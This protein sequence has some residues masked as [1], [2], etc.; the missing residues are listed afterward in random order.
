MSVIAA[1]LSGGFRRDQFYRE[2][3]P[4]VDAAS[5]SGERMTQDDAVRTIAVYA[6]GSLLADTVSTLP[7][8]A[9]VKRGADRL[10]DDLPEWLETP[11]PT[12]PS[13]TRI[14]HMS[15]LM[16]SMVLDNNSFTL[17][18]PDVFDPSE[19]RVCNPTRVEARSSRSGP[20]YRM[21]M[22][23]GGEEEVGPDQM[24]HISRARLGGTGRGISP[25]GVMSQSLATKRAAERLAAK[26]FGNGMFLSG[27][28]LLPGPAAP[29]VIDKL[30]ADI[31]EQYAGAENA[32]KPG[33]FANGA[34]WDVPAINLEQFQLLE[35]NQNVVKEVARAYRIAPYLLGITEP[36]AMA[37]ASVEAQ[38]I[39]FEKF[40]IRPY[41]E[42]I[43]LAYRRLMPGAYIKFDT[44]GLL[45]GDFKTRMEGYAL[46]TGAR[47]QTPAEVRALEDLPPLGSDAVFLE[48]PNNN[49]PDPRYQNL[50]RLVQAGYDPAESLAALG[51]PSIKHTGLPPVTVQPEIQ[52]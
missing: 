19:L 9:Y 48:T 51:L 5:W 3:I 23:G 6:A 30:R 18:L 42:R 1:I 8:H 50:A 36:G 4:T 24:V 16:W 49:A 31:T 43:E 15:Q 47:I 7:V 52:P 13:L 10:P 20:R 37:N 12:D 44:K 22:D 28:V 38:G 26:V 35:T 14:D 21:R 40:T 33:V 17:V 27:Q 29:D 46:S 45:R 39:E 41:I 34:K 25:V 32:F 11:D 2:G